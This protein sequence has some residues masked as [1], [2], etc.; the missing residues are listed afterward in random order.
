MTVPADLDAAAADLERR[1]RTVVA[2]AWDG[3]ARGILA[4]SDTVKTTAPR[5]SPPCGDSG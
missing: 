5:R 2:V 4:V 3:V 1:G